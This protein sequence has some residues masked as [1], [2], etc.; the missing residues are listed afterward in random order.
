MS[1]LIDVI[2][3]VLCL[4]CIV[5]RCSLAIRGPLS[6]LIYSRG[7]GLQGKYPI[8][9][10]TISY[11][12]RR[13]ASCPVRLHPMGWATSDG[14]AHVLSCGYRGPYPHSSPSVLHYHRAPSSIEPPRM[15]A[16]QQRGSARHYTTT[17]I[18]TA[19][20]R[21]HPHSH[22]I[23]LRPL[24]LFSLHGATAGAPASRH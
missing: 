11:G 6:L 15:P 18:C 4:W 5:L 8:W 9:Y 16:S 19:P 10:Y 12:A 24:S 7:V 3:Y 20:P 1:H 22:L 2:P 14:A 17:S 13:A 21:S 23:E